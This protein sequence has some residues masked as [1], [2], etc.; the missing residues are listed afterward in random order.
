MIR[1]IALTGGMATGKSTLL[2]IIEKLGFPTLSCD[3]IVKKLYSQ[4]EIME[5]ILKLGGK[6]LYNDTTKTLNKEKLLKKILENASFKEKLEAFIHPLVWEEIEA[7]FEKVGKTKGKVC[8]VEVPLLYEVGWERY[9]D[10]VWVVLASKNTQI[11]RIKDK[12][13]FPLLLK[14]AETQLPLDEKIKKADRVFSSEQ[15]PE[16]LEK[17]LRRI[18]KEYL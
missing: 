12:T 18:L 17:E 15:S 10:E 11:K 7:F 9:F 5:E 16:E 8:F 3:E 1:K 4:R 2:K 6:E 14:L 13:S